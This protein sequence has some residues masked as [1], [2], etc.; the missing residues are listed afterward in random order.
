MFSLTTE[1]ERDH[2][3]FAWSLS[4]RIYAPSQYE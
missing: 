1:E 3:I 2:V 4:P